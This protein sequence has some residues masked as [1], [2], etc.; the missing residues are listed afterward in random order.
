LRD[1][2]DDLHAM[3]VIFASVSSYFWKYPKTAWRHRMN[4]QA[5]HATK[6]ISGCFPMNHLAAVND[7][8]GDA[9]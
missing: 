7:S 6:P 2:L 1:I 3:P 5:M 4:R 9:N 8:P